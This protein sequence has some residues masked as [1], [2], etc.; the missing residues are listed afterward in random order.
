[1]QRGARSDCAVRFD[2]DFTRCDFWILHTF[3]M[4]YMSPGTGRT[5][6]E[7]YEKEIYQL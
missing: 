1:M 2:I 7:F 3:S 6:S 5:N 4:I